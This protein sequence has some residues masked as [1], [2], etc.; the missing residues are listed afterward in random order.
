M[1]AVGQGGDGRGMGVGR[2]DGAGR[3]WR[4][5]DGTELL[6]A[7]LRATGVR[8]AFRA[9]GHELAGLPGIETVDVGDPELA[10]LLADA[11][12]R[13]SSAPSAH[14]GVALMP[15]RR[16]RLSSQ[17]GAATHPEVIEDLRELPP[18]VAGWSL[19]RV[20]AAIELEIA[21]DLG[22]PVPSDVQPLSLDTSG[23][24][25]LRL[26]SSLASPAIVIVVGPGVV[27]DGQVDGVA[28]AARHT[29]APVLAT[30]GA[31]GA[32]PLDD[33]AW[34]GVVGLQRGDAALAGLEDAE[35]VI[36]AG[37]DGDEAVGVIP[38]HAQV[39]EVEPWHL[40][41]M[42]H[43]WPD[44]STG[45]G[46]AS[47]PTSAGRMLV[48]GLAA[49]AAAGRAADTL[50]LHPARALL[51]VF[52]VF[53]AAAVVAADPGPIGLW[54]ARGVV[55][56]APGSIVVPALPVHGFAAA[57]AIVA[58]LDGRPAVAL[59][60]G[61]PDHATEALLDLAADRRLDVVCDVWGDDGSWSRASEH[62]EALVGARHESGVQRL[63]VPVDMAATDELVEL[64]G[65]VVAWV[66]PP[67]DAG[68]APGW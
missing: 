11:D 3:S 34:R 15:G 17:P 64:A 12:G 28:E 2:G 22:G 45:P 32:L 24:R 9:R 25:L 60:S 40:G 26:A 67:T 53:G 30:P 66:D 57:A 23:G 4:A 63:A 16:L 48:D 41:L 50:P 19:G 6:G 62:R 10:A 37:L 35:L 51:D 38:S 42:A 47:D 29:G 27:R 58:A 8:R 46:V 36:T 65:P 1:S 14:P 49:I 18:A 54:L 21:L 61:P 20:H 31:V 39:L 5:S 13:L 52:E 43:H 33:P 59:V 68:P 55:P 7:C 44:E 56:A